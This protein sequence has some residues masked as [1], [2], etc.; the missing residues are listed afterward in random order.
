MPRPRA[1]IPSSASHDTQPPCVARPGPTSP[2]RTSPTGEP[3][4]ARSVSSPLPPG[5]LEKPRAGASRFSFPSC[6][7]L[8]CHLLL[9]FPP[10]PLSPLAPLRRLP[11]LLRMRCGKATRPRVSAPGEHVEPRDCSPSPSPRATPWPG[12]GA[13][14]LRPLRRAPICRADRLPSLP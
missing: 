11:V 2:R 12:N 3:H 5:Q 6:A 4:P 10:C 13:S 7:Q 1:A 14:E 9:V 8:H